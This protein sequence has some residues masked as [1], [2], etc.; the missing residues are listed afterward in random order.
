[1]NRHILFSFITIG[2]FSCQ[3]GTVDSENILESQASETEYISFGDSTFATDQ[4][5]TAADLVTA[6]KTGAS[7]T[8]FATVAGPIT[9]VCTT[10]GCWMS[11][12]IDSNTNLFV[13]YDYEFLLPTN[14]KDQEMVMTG[15]AYWDSTTVAELKH[16]AQDIG[17]SEEEIASIIDATGEVKFK[18]KGVKVV[19]PA[20]NEE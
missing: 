2:L 5:M 17:A 9:K 4:T 18:A 19:I 13:D 10:K 1:M 3:N 8:V 7:D 16:Y 14:S 6:F 11:T 12:E 15:Y 20:S